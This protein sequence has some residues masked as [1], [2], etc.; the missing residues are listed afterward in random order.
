MP[1]ASALAWLGYVRKK[2]SER[3]DGVGKKRLDHRIPSRKRKAGKKMSI[4]EQ[5]EQRQRIKD[6]DLNQEAAN[7]AT[8]YVQNVFPESMPMVDKQNALNYV[9]HGFA[10]AIRKYEEY[11]GVTDGK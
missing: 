5:I 3:N 1:P 11:R 2:I 9:A 8:Y 10:M 7:A 6:E 4:K